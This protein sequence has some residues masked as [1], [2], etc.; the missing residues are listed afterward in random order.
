MKKTCFS[1]QYGPVFLASLLFVLSGC[2]AKEQLADQYLA[3]NSPVKPGL[4]VYYRYAFYRH[5]NQMA[6]DK[7]MITEGEA[8]QPIPLLNHQFQG[9]IFGSKKQKGV[10]VLLTGYLK[11]ETPGSY[12]FKAMSND[13][14]QVTVNQQVVAFD[15]AVHS[16][17][18]SPVGEVFL[19]APGWYS[20][21]VNYFQRKGTARLEL[22]WQP[23]GAEGFVVV[24]AEMYA[25]LD[26]PER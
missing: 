22:H 19:D 8:G 11:I 7:V 10:A 6:T 1:K 5:I 24:P 4:S 18:F 17:R 2:G 12:R 20:L 13:G 9:N 21:K 25:H 23:P 16:D 14:V 26:E 15:P 3:F